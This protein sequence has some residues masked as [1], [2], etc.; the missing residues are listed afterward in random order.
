MI[1]VKLPVFWNSPDKHRQRD[2][3]TRVNLL[4]LPSMNCE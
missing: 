1:E 3:D 4:A 2:K